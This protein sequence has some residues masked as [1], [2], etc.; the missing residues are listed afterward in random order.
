MKIEKILGICFFLFLVSTMISQSAMDVFATLSALFLLIIWW[1]HRPGFKLFPNTGLEG[2]FLAF[3]VAVCLSFISNWPTQ[4]HALSRILELK[5]IFNFYLIL[6][7]LRWLR[8]DWK[9]FRNVEI[10]IAVTALFAL[11]AP[12]IGYDPLQ[13]PEAIIDRTPSGVARVGGFFSNPMTYAHL[14][15]LI[16][17]LLAGVGLHLFSEKKKESWQVLGLTAL[18]GLALLLTFTRG[19]WI[20][21][22]AGL[23]VMGFLFRARW[24]LWI[25][26]ACVAGGLVLFFAVP[27]V[28]ERALQMVSSS[29]YDSERVWI[30]KAN[31]QM[32]KEHPLFGMGHGENTLALKEYYG[33]V[34]APEGL[35]ISH[36]HNQYLNFLSGTGILGFVAYLS[37]LAFA[38]AAAFRLYR[39]IRTQEDIPIWLKGLV[40]GSMAAQV[41]FWIGG[42]TESNFEHSKVRYVLLLT[43]AIPFWIRDSV[44]NGIVPDRSD[45]I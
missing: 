31:L 38:F 26:T 39:T 9:A 13:S 22:F 25:L 44:Q 4:T 5:W 29:S 23:V 24:G 7:A 8:P 30:W 43:W 11:V 2:P 19:V 28:Q 36:S 42:L 34:G 14:H 15:A 18:L 41:S 27:S 10:W 40:L 20:G 6:A 16:F 1:K 35:I 12:V 32:F 17:F 21:M 37:L 3:A 45:K 33:K